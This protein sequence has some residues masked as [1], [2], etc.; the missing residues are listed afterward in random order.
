[1]S[2]GKNVVSLPQGGRDGPLDDRAQA[3]VAISRMLGGDAVMGPVLLALG[4]LP[5]SEQRILCAIMAWRMMGGKTLPA[6]ASILHFP[7]LAGM[8]MD[9]VQRA[10]QAMDESGLIEFVPT[11]ADKS[12]EGM[13]GGFRWPAFDAVLTAAMVRRQTEAASPIV[14]LDGV[15]IDE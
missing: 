11:K 13:E 2:E 8:G 15:P 1:M 4:N 12:G 14:G 6:S 3:F 7:M 10:T 5:R 9:E